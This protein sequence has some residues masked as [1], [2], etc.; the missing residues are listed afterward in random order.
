[1]TFWKWLEQLTQRQGAALQQR[2]CCEQ[3]GEKIQ[4]ELYLGVSDWAKRN[5]N[6]CPV[7]G[8]YVL[9]SNGRDTP[10]DAGDRQYHGSRFTEGEW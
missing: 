6:S 9:G 8:G 3:C 7:C 5:T 10:A 4:T 2:Q 1:M